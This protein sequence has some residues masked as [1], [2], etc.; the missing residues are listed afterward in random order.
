MCYVHA[1]MC[2]C[3]YICIY[4]L[5]VQ[6]SKLHL[7]KSEYDRSAEYRL[8]WKKHWETQWITKNVIFLSLFLITPNY[9]DFLYQEIA[10]YSCEREVAGR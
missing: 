1:Y 9:P 6:N 10:K 7:I 8:Y 5:I 4:G 2:I 3:V